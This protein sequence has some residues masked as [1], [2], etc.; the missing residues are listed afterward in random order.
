MPTS[1]LRDRHSNHPGRRF[2]MHRRTDCSERGGR[3]DSSQ[4]R[5]YPVGKLLSSARVA[6]GDTVVPED[7]RI[8]DAPEV[9]PVRTEQCALIGD[10]FAVARLVEQPV[11][12]VVQ[13]TRTNMY[14]TR[15]EPI[16]RCCQASGSITAYSGGIP[17]SKAARATAG[18]NKKY[19]ATCAVPSVFACRTR[20][21]IVA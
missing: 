14:G 3:R 16:A 7:T 20:A 13:R 5:A 11:K 8:V 18:V 19:R 6:R 21:V 1:S 15:V 17:A 4:E 9:L 10:A 12:R 2:R